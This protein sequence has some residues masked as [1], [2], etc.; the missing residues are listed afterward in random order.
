MIRMLGSSR[1]SA[2]QSVLTSASGLTYS[3]IV[4]SCGESRR[5]RCGR[6][7]V[8]GSA[9]G[10]ADEPAGEALAALGPGAVT[11]EPVPQLRLVGGEDIEVGLPRQPGLLQGRAPAAPQVGGHGVRVDQQLGGAAG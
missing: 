5:A 6:R 11:P 7:W 1:R 4:S 3:A 8:R 10:T 9:V 2:S